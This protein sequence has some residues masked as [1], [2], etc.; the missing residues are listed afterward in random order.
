M[1]T[2]R[3]KD[4]P[5]A[6]KI[7]PSQLRRDVVSGDWI[8]L[9]TGRAKRPE[10]FIKKRI[11]KRARSPI[12][13][14]PFED[15][16]KTGH[17]QPL[18]LYKNHKD[19]EVQIIP[20]KFPA[21]THHDVCPT[22]AG[23]GPFSLLDGVGHH[24]VLITR[25]H[26]ANFPALKPRVAELVFQALRDRYLMLVNDP[27]LA[28]VSIFH[29][30]G[31]AAGASIF[32]PHLQ[33]IAIPV[34]PPDVQHSLNGSKK[35]F[36]ERRKCVHCVIIDWEKEKKSRVVF[37]NEGA[38]AFAPFVSREPFEIRVFPKKHL[39][40]FENTR[41]ED[42]ADIVH[43][44]QKVLKSVELN[45]GDPDY[46][47]FIHTAPMREKEKFDHYHWHIEIRPKIAIQAGFEL[48]TGIDINVIDPDD[49]AKIL[50][51]KARMKRKN[52]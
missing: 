11:G 27:C 40:Y 32:H 36:D 15:P 33:L 2:K 52:G 48:G 42:F 19:W 4:R 20:N 12:A 14:C 35:Y 17:G 7:H 22:L 8:V 10:D 50:K 5:L 37:E 16:Q 21:L 46:N 45:L 28:Y 25:D 38:I 47:F 31:P 3:K 51:T 23:R 24:D 13:A 9:A 41:D 6:K 49:A 43:V 26:N 44:L 34:I 18:L 29:N 30:W 39:P 1:P